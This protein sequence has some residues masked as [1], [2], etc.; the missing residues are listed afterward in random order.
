MDIRRLSTDPELTGHTN[1]VGEF[2]VGSRPDCPKSFR[3]FSMGKLSEINKSVLA[4]LKALSA[5][6][7]S[8]LGLGDF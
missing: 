1:F 8:A 7:S 6:G 4:E 2:F 5:D 3:D